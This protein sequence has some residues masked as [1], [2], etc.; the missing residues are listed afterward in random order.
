MKIKVNGLDKEVEK[1]QTILEALQSVGIEVP[2]LCHIKGLFPSGACRMCI[3][4]VEGFPN[5]I[6]SCAY[7]IS[8]GM[9]I[10]THSPRAVQARK[11]IIELLLSNHPD[12]CLYCVR[13]KNC[14]LQDL[15]A[16]YGVRERVFSQPKPTHDMDVSSPAL[17]RD[18]AKCI[19]CGK[20]VRVCEEVMGVSAIDFVHRGSKTIIAPAFEE[21]MNMSSC[22]NC[23]Q[24]I[25][26]CPTGALREQSHT[27]RVLR[28]LMDPEIHVVAQHAPAISVTLAEEWGLKTDA[29]AT[30]ILNATLRKL[31]FDSVF[32]TGYTADLT[33]MEEASE[34][35]H[36][37]QN[38]G[39]LPMMTTCSPAW[40]KYMEQ[41]YP[42]LLPHL[43]SCKS[44]H[45]MMGALTKTAY[46]E[47][48]C[49]DPDRMFVVSIMPCTAKKFEA[50]RAEMRVDN[51]QDVD[52]VLTT[53]E[54]L[55]MV[56][57][58]GLDISTLS[59]A[60][61]DC[62]FGE[63]SSAGKLFGATGGVME[64]AVRT[65]QYFITG[66][67]PEEWEVVAVRGLENMKAVTLKVGDLEVNVAVVNGVGSAKAVLD[68]I[69]EGKS[70]FHFVEVMSCPGGCIGGGGQPLVTNPER[71]KARMKSLYQMDSK[72]S[73]RASHRNPA[74]QEL[75]HTFLGEPL[76]HK[77]H[78]L[79]H[80]QYES[81]A[82]MV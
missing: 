48:E 71:I 36:R 51:R 64:A 7:P 11:M 30:G 56:N 21:G 80:T 78:E 4:E 18:Q 59:P 5:L 76:G 62:P 14:H 50:D 43:S 19:L 37:I 68:E 35:V 77:S 10:E 45:Q 67:D 81:R 82:V 66:E 31:G 23:G 72:E 46:A 52:A 57:T 3:V 16:D 70:N 9:V 27:D 2:T 32:D 49:L 79:L 60:E 6:P 39:V 17:I 75:Y 69:R 25:V 53:R 8:E 33:I 47:R 54:L 44:P 20:C 13:N 41:L 1:D 15:A 55:R 24:C 42:D 74:I 61:A 28:A 63:R 65:A 34:L 73:I 58:F 40:V 22:I 26:V 12:D 38:N 29:D